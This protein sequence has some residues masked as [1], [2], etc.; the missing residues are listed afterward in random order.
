MQLVVHVYKST[1]SSEDVQAYLMKNDSPG[2]RMHQY[3]VVSS[4]DAFGCPQGVP[5]R[6]KG[7]GQDS[8]VGAA[9]GE[10]VGAT[11][12]A[13]VGALVGLTVG[14]KVVGAAVSHEHLIWASTPTWATVLAATHVPAPPSSP[15]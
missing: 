13:I 8:R 4:N 14:A 11:V 15:S 1:E 7:V 5:I 9:V 2:A 12:G 3:P 10:A 6:R